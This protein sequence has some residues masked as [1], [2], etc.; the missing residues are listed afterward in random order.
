MSL[1]SA[2]GNTIGYLT[3]KPYFDHHS[4]KYYNVICVNTNISGPL[5]SL[6]KQLYMPPVSTY[7]NHS[8]SEHC[9]YVIQN[10]YSSGF[11]YYTLEQL[12]NLFIFMSQNYYTINHEFYSQHIPLNHNHICMFSYS[13][14]N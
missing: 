7:K 8:H 3:H 13:N 6:I 11:P 10:H 4:R 5:D 2:S 14:S 9:S 12:Q 1:P